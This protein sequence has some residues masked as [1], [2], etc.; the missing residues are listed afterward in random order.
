MQNP[1]ATLGVDKNADQDTIRKAYKKLARKYHPDINKD[2]GAEERFK[3]INS[4]YDVLGDQEKRK[5]F[6]TFGEASTRPGFDAD[7]ARAWQQR[8]GGG[9]MP[10]GFGGMPGGF[11]GAGVDMEDLLGSL[12]GAGASRGPRRG[13][14]QSTRLRVDFMTTVLGG[15]RT[16]QLQRPNGSVESV[17]V[18]I[19]AGAK[20]G[21]RV[22]LRGKGAPPRGG[23]PCGDL[24]VELQ[25]APHPTLVRDGNDLHLE[26][27]ITVHEAMAGATVTV[28]TPTGDVKV[29][30]PKGAENG[31]KLRIK[32]R[33]IQRKGQP[34]H[35]YL[36]LR[37]T[38]PST[39]DEAALEA[40]KA[41]DAFYAGDVRKD[42]TI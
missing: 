8:G 20:D 3:S 42:L 2:P 6:D 7:A 41:L 30:V 37:P 28:P 31:Q 21:G 11:G 16:I 10:G 27:P 40:A 25:V 34:G 35:L 24:L 22:R 9:G 18:P 5:L 14:D 36:I 26:V 29:T 15:E 13:A 1:Y 4:A 23:G 19:P 17:T 32:G 38:V 12:F 39:Q 33:G